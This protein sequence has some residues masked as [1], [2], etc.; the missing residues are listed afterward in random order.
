MNPPT[1]QVLSKGK[2]FQKKPQKP[3]IFQAPAFLD[4]TCALIWKEALESV[5]G[6]DERSYQVDRTDDID[7]CMRMLAAGM[8]S[9]DNSD[10]LI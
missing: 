4:S 6:Y 5:G 9:L 10:F 3:S 2:T 7:L 8:K 1:I